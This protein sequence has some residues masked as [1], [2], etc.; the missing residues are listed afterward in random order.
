MKHI[1]CAICGGDNS[2]TILSSCDKYLCVDKTKFTL[3]RCNSCGLLYLNPQPTMAELKKYYPPY[4]PSYLPHYDVLEHSRSYEILKK[5][6][7]IILPDQN[8]KAAQSPMEMIDTQTHKKVL[9]FGCGSGNFLSSLKKE[10]PQWELYGFDISANKERIKSDKN[11]IVFYDDFESLLK[12]FPEEFFDK[13]YLNNVL[14][15]LNDPVIILKN[16]ASLLHPQGEIIIEV[17]NI[18]SIK[19]KIFRSNFSALDIPRHLYHFNPATLL[20][21][22]KKCG[23]TIAELTSVG[24]SKGTVRSINYAFGIHKDK[25]NPILLFI[26]DKIAK[27]IGEKRINDDSMIARVKKLF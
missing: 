20:A 8:K 25:I 23:L 24:S 15:H 22:C 26:V 18:N 11:I 10:H 12:H 14:E 9:D 27:F 4:Y 3:V 1:P 7:R 5:I 21:L 6:K 2:S 17:P 16:L 19:F 13:I